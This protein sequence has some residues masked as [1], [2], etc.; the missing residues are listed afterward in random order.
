MKEIAAQDVMEIL[1]DAD[2][3]NITPKQLASLVGAIEAIR[4]EA[5]ADGYSEGEKEGRADAES[6]REFPF[7]NNGTIEELRLGIFLLQSGDK[8]AARVYLDRAFSDLGQS[9]T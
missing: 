2:I 6:E 9:W 1:N 7:V 4:D 3:D 8:D 5:E